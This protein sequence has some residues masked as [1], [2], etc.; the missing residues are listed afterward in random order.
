V[1]ATHQLWVLNRVDRIVWMEDGKIRTM[2][3][4]KELMDTNEE[5][6]KLIANNAQEDEKEEE[7]EVV[8]DEVEDEKK[9]QDRHKQ[10]K[11]GAALMQ[12]EE[13]ATK[14]VSTEVYMAYIKASGSILVLPFVFILLV[15]SQGSSIATNLWLSY[16]T[17]N[18]FGYS[19]G[20]YIVRIISSECS[21][22]KC[23]EVMESTVTFSGRCLSCLRSNTG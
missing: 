20:A 7:V 18:K 11:K 14:G 1:L 8:E 3:T 19:T 23:E 4:F 10:N 6:V 21:R 13:R 5:F 12:V 9:Q 2:G 17:S 15:L 22:T 16:W